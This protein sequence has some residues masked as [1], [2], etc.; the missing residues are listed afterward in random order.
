MEWASM[1]KMNVDFFSY[2]RRPSNSSV[3]IV[4]ISPQMVT[5]SPGTHLLHLGERKKKKQET[6]KNM[7]RGKSGISVYTAFTN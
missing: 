1:Y 3:R 2:T 7:Q 6:R 4:L 5:T